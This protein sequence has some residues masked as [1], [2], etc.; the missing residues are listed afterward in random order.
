MKT[1]F[2]VLIFAAIALIVFAQDNN[3]AVA[4][5]ADNNDWISL[6][7]DMKI[8]NLASAKGSRSSSSYSSGSRSYGSYSGSYGSSY[9]STFGYSYSYGYTGY[10][11]GYYGYG[12]YGY[13]YNNGTTSVVGTIIGLTIFGCIFCGIF[14]IICVAACK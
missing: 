12:Y 1:A 9:G 8:D 5:Q 3:G 7:D 10:G 6:I 13:G 14:V 2:V 11:Y 4:A